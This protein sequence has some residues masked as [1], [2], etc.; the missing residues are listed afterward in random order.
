MAY[1]AAPGLVALTR[2]GYGPR[3]DGDTRIAG[4]DPRGF[5]RAELAQPGIA[6]L[7]GPGLPSTATA[8]QLFFKDQAAR[9]AERERNAATAEHARLY[10]ELSQLS[11]AFARAEAAGAVRTPEAAAHDTAGVVTT[12]ES[13]P[14]AKPMKPAPS[15]E[16]TVFRDEA[17]ARL[18]RAIEARAGFAERLVAFWSNHFCVSAAKGGIARVTAGSFE[19][20]AIRPHVLGRFAD[21]LLAAEGHPA[22]LHFL[23]NAQSVG[24][25]SRAGGDGRRGLNENLGREIMELHVL[26]TGAG[27]TQA[28][29]TNLSRIITGWTYVGPQAKLGVPG[30]FAFNAA[31]HEPGPIELLGATY[32]ENG[33]EQGRAALLAL[34]R[35]PRCAAFIAGKFARAF[36]G[37]APS[38]ALVDRLARTFRDTDGDLRALSLTLVDA[39]EAWDARPVRVRTPYEFLLGAHRLLQRLPEEPG[40]ILGPLATMGMALWT[41]PGP[42]G[43]PDQAAA[44]ATPEGMKLRLDW[45]AQLAGRL[46]EPPNPSDLLDALSGGVSSSETREAVA[47]AESR[48]QG[49]ALLLMSPEMQRS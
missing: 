37:E 25:N 33:V 27:Y 2:F 9:R 15:P 40:A 14:G 26:G 11:P 12:P 24:P 21:M 13:R 44:W 38:P 6:L 45:S 36:L 16:G 3:G 1:D 19:R 20:E 23:D 8:V 35:H 5:L 30:T 22:M 41:P 32:V 43:Y 42:N 17:L 18:R 29:V 49:L 7:D 4:A 10:A 28:D 34:T 39:P 46:R 47:H 48:Q 31:A